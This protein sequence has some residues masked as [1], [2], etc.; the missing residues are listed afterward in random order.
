VEGTKT[1]HIAGA[2]TTFNVEKTSIEDGDSNLV[3]LSLPTPTG[4]F[5]SIISTH[6]AVQEVDY[7]PQVNTLLYVYIYIY[8]RCI[9]MYRYTQDVSVYMDNMYRCICITYT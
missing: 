1:H 5:E 9:C 6:I 8:Y 2:G 7:L 3:L 4:F